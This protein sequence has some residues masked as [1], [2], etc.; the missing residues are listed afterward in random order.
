MAET[1]TELKLDVAVFPLVALASAGVVAYLVYRAFAS[2]PTAHDTLEA[3]HVYE[4][5]VTPRTSRQAAQT[6]MLAEFPNVLGV[7]ELSGQDD[8]LFRWAPRKDMPVPAELSDGSTIV[9]VV[10]HE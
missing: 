1:N 8:F 9:S 5:R 2:G 3:G 10:E 6:A 4:F 7:T